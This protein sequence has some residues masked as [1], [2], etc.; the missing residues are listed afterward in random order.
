MSRPSYYRPAFDIFAPLYDFG[1]WLIGLLLGGERKLRNLAV[2][3]ISPAPGCK[4]L[5]ICCGTATISLMSA[6]K[7]AS[8]YGLDISRGMLNVAR[9]KAQR[10]KVNLRLVQPA[11][12]SA[13]CKKDPLPRHGDELRVHEMPFDV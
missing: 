2:E 5:E 7:G 13:P 9:E 10:Q 6:E 12:A 3:T 1:I 8:V 4:T 11:R